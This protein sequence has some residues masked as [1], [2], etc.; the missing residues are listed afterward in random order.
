MISGSVAGTTHG[1]RRWLL[2]IWPFLATV[3][4]LLLLSNAS[5]HVMAGMRAFVSAE[6]LWSKA[7][8][9]AV[10]HLEQYAQTR[11]EDAYQRYLAE[12]AVANGMRNARIE[13]DKPHPNLEIVRDG[14]RDARNHP[15]DIESMIDLFR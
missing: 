3:T 11:N 8:K 5:L 15:A 2:I 10:S 4:L 9:T 13:L 6:S 14:F 1:A 12:I 7:Q